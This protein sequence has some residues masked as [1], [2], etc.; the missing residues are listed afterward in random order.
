MTEDL[1]VGNCSAIG[2]D[3][4][5]AQNFW[6][7]AA[8]EGYLGIV[9]VPANCTGDRCADCPDNAGC[10]DPACDNV[11]PTGVNDQ[12][13]YCLG[14]TFQN[15]MDNLDARTLSTYAASGGK[16]PPPYFVAPYSAVGAGCYRVGNP[17]CQGTPSWS[18]SLTGKIIEDFSEDPCFPS[19]SM[20]TKADGNPSRIDALK[21]G[22]MIVAATAEGTLTTD[23][24]SLL[25][26]A[27]P[28]AHAKSFLALTT[29][30]NT[31]LTLTPGHHVPVGAVCC[32]TLKKAKDVE[33]GE[34]MWAVKDG[35]A[36]ATTVTTKTASVKAS[37]LHS[38][39]LV[40]GGFPVVDGLVTSFDS[41]DKVT[42]A[43]HG[44]AP[45]LTA[46]KATG[47]CESFR[48][49]FLGADERNFIG[50]E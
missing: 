23:K 27:M 15:C 16:A 20:I 9:K 35:K 50:S 31:T 40:N 11:C 45:L 14:A 19:S 17:S 28:E 47:T 21:E 39:V 12:T 3:S 34:K 29:A 24:V 30:A 7:A 8:A 25:S 37:G 2:I 18:L 10:D 46:C 41:I 22:D 36:V 42:L 1:I 26:I 32:S 43:K 4:Q 33:V 6:G 44:L 13:F 48:D 5:T 49:M 38:P